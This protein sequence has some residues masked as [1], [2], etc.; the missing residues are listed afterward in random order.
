MVLQ[1]QVPGREQVVNASLKKSGMEHLF[2]TNIAV[3]NENIVY[4]VMFDNEQYN[5]S[6][7]AKN[8][9]F[10]SFSFRREHDQ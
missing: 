2:S 4:N 9:S 10:P 8:S 5:F 6:S 7:E 3:N 1:L